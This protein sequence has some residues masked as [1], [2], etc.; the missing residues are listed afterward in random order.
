MDMALKDYL[1]PKGERNGFMFC[2]CLQQ[3][4]DMGT[5]V[6]DIVFTDGG[7]YC[8]S[9]YNDY[10]STLALVYILAFT[11]QIIN[12][13]VKTILRLAS[14]L[15]KRVN[16]ADE[17]I[18]NIFKMSLTQI[19]NTAILLLVVNMKVSFLPSWFPVFA[20]D[21]NDFTTGWYADVGATIMIMMLFSIVTP[22][23]ANFFL[24][25]VRFIR[26]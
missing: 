16:K 26:R 2:Y 6:K 13:I 22:H 14:K 25:F 21:Y 9:W 10:M 8:S 24:H 15:E 7:T 20:G 12:V 18:S 17:V 19:I 11:M 5:S 3:Y 1:N 23:I 4:N